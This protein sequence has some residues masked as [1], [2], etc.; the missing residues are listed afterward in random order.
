[1]INDFDNVGENTLTM[2]RA[3]FNDYRRYARRDMKQEILESLQEA[4]E[5]MDS[6]S[7]NLGGLILSIKLVEGI[8]E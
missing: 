4:L 6:K 8:N 5:E 3:L 2:S 1:V 7:P